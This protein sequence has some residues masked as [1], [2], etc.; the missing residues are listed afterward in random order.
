MVLSG[1]YGVLLIA[2]SRSGGIAASWQA[3]SPNPPDAYRRDTADA[4]DGQRRPAILSDDRN[5]LTNARPRRAKQRLLLPTGSRPTRAA[6]ASP[7][8]PASMPQANAS[9]LL[10]V[11]ALRYAAHSCTG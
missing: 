2:N 7:A 3:A 6:N 4:L 10:S 11:A 8:M 1:P 5:G 9:L